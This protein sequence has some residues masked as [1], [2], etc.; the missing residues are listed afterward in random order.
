MSKRRYTMT[1]IYTDG[2]T[3]TTEY[4]F[5]YSVSDAL[6]RIR[7]SNDYCHDVASVIVHDSKYGEDKVFEFE[8]V[9]E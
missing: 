7:Q 6:A 2:Y 4:E 3:D 8:G 9:E 1:T 5:L